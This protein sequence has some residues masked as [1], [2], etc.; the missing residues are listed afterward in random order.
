MLKNKTL[1]EIED[2]A[3]DR[4]ASFTSASVG[5]SRPINEKFQ[6]SLDATITDF[7]GTAASGGV[8]ATEGTGNEYFYAAQLIGNGVITSDD[9]LIAGLRFADLD[10]SNY[11]VMDLSL[12]YPLMDSLKV[13][14][15]LMLGYRTGDTTD[16]VEYTV[17]PSVLV[18]Y[19]LTRDLSLELEVGARWTDTTENNV[20]ETST[21]LFFTIG[22]RYDFYADGTVAPQS[23][24]APYGAGGPK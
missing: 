12:R 10:Q 16:L 13:N 8:A 1:A 20:E 6:V 17:L 11:Y 4:T 19:Y 5:F 3:V 14:P 22:Y 21:D 15:R 2:L 7:S 18:D 9:L 24:T 23:R